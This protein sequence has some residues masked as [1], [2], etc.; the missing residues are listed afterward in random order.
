MNRKH[1]RT[2]TARERAKLWAKALCA[3]LCLSLLYAAACVAGD[4]RFDLT[5]NHIGALSGATKD[6]LNTLDIDVNILLVF[7]QSTDSEHRRAVETV[8]RSY[9]KYPHITI[10]T[11]DPVREPGRLKAFAQNGSTIGEGRIVVA[12]ADCTRGIVIEPQECYMYQQNVAGGYDMTG[13]AIE[14]KLTLAIQALTDSDKGRVLF[15][16]G[17]DEAS[18][19]DCG[20]LA[21]RLREAGYEAC[22]YAL[23]SGET[24]RSDD[25]LMILSPG[26]DLTAEELERINAF[27]DAGGRA[28]ICF[29][30]SLD[31][32][33]LAR[34]NLLPERYSISYTPGLVVEDARSTDNWI[35]SPMYLMPDVNRAAE[36]LEGFPAGRRILIPAARPLS[37][38]GIPLSGYTYRTLLSSSELAYIKQMDSPSS[39]YEQGDPRG[40]W[41]LA[42]SVEG[43]GGTRVV[44][45][46]TL[47]TVMDN[48]LMS[49][50]Y[51]L[52]LTMKLISWLA[53]REDPLSIPVKSSVMHAMA[54][55]STEQGYRI[56]AC[57]LILPA[58][59][60]LAAVTVLIKRRKQR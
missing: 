28:F 37:G 42:V 53:E 27:L 47:Y 38:P 15:L 19:S 57:S 3:I 20:Q 46:G 44:M 11:V 49:A 52:D 17:H 58:L 32:E 4:I 48:G 45:L 22:D 14:R 43:T 26:R 2:V 59:S 16:S 13:I 31:L 50:S 35:N 23:M 7:Q 34:F 41:Q 10:D 36:A 55:P 8:A 1:T 40:T 18:V 29:D 9:E 25:I 6:F 24:L 21:E 60:L 39:D 30:A 51:N 56:L 33:K 5:E 54:V 12:N